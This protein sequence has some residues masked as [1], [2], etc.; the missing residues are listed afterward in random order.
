[1]G[2]NSRNTY[3]SNGLINH[4]YFELTDRCNLSCKH[5]Y[6]SASPKG[7]NIL[8]TDII[9]S[10]IS[11]F[12]EIGGHFVTFSGGEPLLHPDWENLILYTKS[13][14]LNCSIMTNCS[15]VQKETLNKLLLGDALITIS[16]DGWKEE[17]HDFIRGKGSFNK[18]QQVLK[19]IEDLKVQDRVIICFTPLKVN[20]GDFHFL[21]TELSNRGFLKYYLSLLEERGRMKYSINDLS[22]CTEEK[23]LLLTE[24]AFL[25]LNLSTN[26]T[27]D[28]G[29]LKHFFYQLLD[30]NIWEGQDDLIEGTLRIT[31]T[32][33]IYL[34]AYSEGYRFYLGN[35][36]SNGLIECSTSTRFYRLLSELHQ[37][38]SNIEACC[39]CPYRIIC[40]GGSPARAYTK[41]NDFLFPDD[42]CDAKKIFLDDWFLAM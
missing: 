13:K 5:C 2:M 8:K 19:L 20:L 27:V 26:A 21:V 34:S 18:V 31:S 16:L 1:M 36:N 6:L 35:L 23:V 24:L 7:K 10:A 28:T 15:L 22:L 41:Y 39:T 42:Y 40:G 3:F 30:S 37:R 33:D 9:K 14:N 11:E 25:M 4:L 29:H 17:T 12:S 38:V 32:G